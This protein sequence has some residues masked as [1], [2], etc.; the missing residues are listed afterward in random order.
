MVVAAACAQAHSN[1]I[2]FIH[3]ERARVPTL[4]LAA[5]APQVR[6]KL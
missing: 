3:W 5:A 1:A 4:R 6:A 2:G